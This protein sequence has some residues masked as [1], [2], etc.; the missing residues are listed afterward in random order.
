MSRNRAILFILVAIS[1][2][3]G[4]I[5]FGKFAALQMTGYTPLDFLMNVYY[6]ASLACLAVQAVVWP[7]VLRSMPL[8][9]SYLFMSAIYLIIPVISHFVFG[10]Q[11][12]AWNLGGALVVAAGIVLLCTGAPPAEKAP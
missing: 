11:I 10:E 9:W 3:A 4:S 2:Q 6:L 8:F 12:S 7:L 1:C 5:T